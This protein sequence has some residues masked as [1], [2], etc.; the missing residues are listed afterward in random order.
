MVHPDGFV[1]RLGK[2]L[3]KMGQQGVIRSELRLM[4]HSVNARNGSHQYYLTRNDAPTSEPSYKATIPFSALRL[5]AKEAASSRPSCLNCCGFAVL[6]SVR[7]AAES[8]A[9]ICVAG[10]VVMLD[11]AC[12]LSNGTPFVETSKA[13]LHGL[14]SLDGLEH[15]SE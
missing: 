2:R 1:K 6:T 15:G 8:E 13:V 14:G 3:S 4:R 11:G 9:S 12:S 7:V 10:L 5:V